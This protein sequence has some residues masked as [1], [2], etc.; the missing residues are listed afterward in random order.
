MDL[1]KLNYFFSFSWYIYQHYI[2]CGVLST[3][4]CDGS[5]PSVF[6]Q[7]SEPIPATIWLSVFPLSWA[8]AIAYFFPAWMH[9]GSF[10]S[11]APACFSSQH[12][13]HF[14]KKNFCAT[15]YFLA[16]FMVSVYFSINP[17]FILAASPYFWNRVWCREVRT[18]C[19]KRQQ[20]TEVFKFK[21]KCFLT[22]V[23]LVDQFILKSIPAFS[24]LGNR[25]FHL[26][27]RLFYLKPKVFLYSQRSFFLLL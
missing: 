4:C 27:F 17:S 24:L 22:D 10:R 5:S 8:L 11:F 3:T 13:L 25:F 9:T 23:P 21:V 1:K 18:K 15:S 26:C 7:C 19:S 20:V 12:I 6:P 14:L 2:I 16:S